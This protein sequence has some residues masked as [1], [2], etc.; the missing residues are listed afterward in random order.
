MVETGVLLSFAVLLITGIVIGAPLVVSLL[1]G[2]VLFLGYGLWRKHSPQELLGMSLQGLKT[3]QHVLILFAIIGMLTATWRAA[4]TIA[5]IT[6][7]SAS[8]MRPVTLTVVTFFICSAMSFLCGSSFG[9]A[10]TAGV[11]CFTIGKALGAEPALLG[12]A[13]LSGAFFG[14]RC[15]PMSSSAALI[16]NLT[17]TDI[18]ENIG[19][20]MRSASIPFVASALVFTLLG[21]SSTSNAAAPDFH[22][23]FS[24]AFVLN[25]IVLIPIVLVLALAFMHV[26]VKKSMMLSLLSALV[27]C[28]T[29]QGDSILDI[30]RLLIFGY[31]CEDPEVA[32][33]VNGGGIISMFELTCIVS[34]ASTYSGIF[35]GTGLLKNLRDAI[36]DISVRTTPFIGVLLTSILTAIIACDQVVCIMLTS[37]LCDTCEGTGTALAL[38]ME[39][40]SAIMP[41][42][43]PWST[44]VIGILAFTGAPTTSVLFAFYPMFIPLWTVVLSVYE[45]KHPNFVET[46]P[47]RFMGLNRNDDIR[48]VKELS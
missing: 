12:G 36:K 6:S 28:V 19:R 34:I 31:V 25:P 16:A 40:S 48:L 3:V 44:S 46:K 8:L 9:A 38:D 15:S 42:L 27:I 22:T 26:E 30:P 39:N 32:S 18:T 4:G 41:A 35:N 17:H 21:L 13:I 20:M 11:A 23:M 43:V 2:L 29:L 45:R 14:D 10:A 24:T 37:Q 33:M 7:W 47:A 1:L 5:F